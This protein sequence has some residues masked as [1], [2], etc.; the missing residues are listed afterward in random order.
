MSRKESRRA[1]WRLSALLAAALLVAACGETTEESATDLVQRAEQHLVAKEYRAAIIEAKN[2]LLK[3]AEAANARLVLARAY[4]ALGDYGSAEN[5]FLRAQRAGAPPAAYVA[6]LGETLL[7][8]AAYPRVLNLIIDEPAA[9][10]RVRADVLAVRGLAYL[11]QGNGQK[12]RESFNEALDLIPT[13]VRA[14]VGQ[15]RLD[16]FSGIDVRPVAEKLVAEHGDNP[17][18]LRLQGD[19]A[20]QTADFPTAVEAYGR[21][22]ALRPENPFF[23]MPQAYAQIAVG[24]TDAAIENVEWVLERAA[25]HPG[26]LYLRALAAHQMEDYATAEAFSTQTLSVLPDHLPSQLIAGSAGYALGHL[27]QAARYLEGYLTHV[28]EHE[29]ARKLHAATLLRL[30]KGD[31]AFEALEP[32][33]DQ[34]VGDPQTL[35]LLGQAAVGRGDFGAGRAF[36]RDAVAAKPDHA[37]TRAQLGIIEI[38]LGNYEA[39]IEELEKA[40]DLDPSFDPALFV[41]FGSYMRAE[42]Y[43][44]AL[45]VAG[46]YAES[47]PD[48][49]TGQTLAGIVHAAREDVDAAREAFEEALRIQPGAP[50]ASINLAVLAVR[51][52][53]TE[54]AR[55]ILMS[56]HE[57]NPRNV[58]IMIRLAQIEGRST[59]WRDARLWLE[60]AVEADPN[61][62]PPRVML[63]RLHLAAG[64]PLNALAVTQDYLAIRPD[65]VDVL[66]IVGQA[67]MVA[68]QPS[69]AEAT[70]R[71]LVD[72]QPDSAENF[73]LLAGAYEAQRDWQRQHDAISRA[74]AIDPD[75]FD[76]L[77]TLTRNYGH[78]EDLDKFRETLETLRERAPDNPIVWELTGNLAVAEDRFD[79]AV[80]DYRKAM[81]QSPEPNRGVA[82]KLAMAQ[83]QS[84]DRKASVATTADWLTRFPDDHLSRLEM[85]NRFMSMDRMP[86]AEV[87]FARLVE[88]LPDSWVARNNLAWVQLQRGELATAREHA[89][90]AATLSQGNPSVLDTLGLVLLAQDRVDR[91]IVTL[92]KA[93]DGL[94]ES[95]DVKVHLAQ[96]LAAGGQSDEA[97]ALLAEA[98]AGESALSDRDAAERLLAELGG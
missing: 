90:R 63:A 62:A 70:F 46:R 52:D 45:D 38:G 31:A 96:A 92:R 57:A 87:E 2:A 17:D 6:D 65:D 21:L 72:V 81:D 15:A 20:F 42:D 18:A 50:D 37:A 94:P 77:V 89:E 73:L 13:H 67:Q 55:Q 36:L 48:K 34:P 85:A 29:Q 49:S 24:Q 53:D 86:E 76:A 47:H 83:W 54:K 25:N 66:R 95:G 1:T 33:V 71:R 26:A 23:R 5:E 64:D 68:D 79:D 98:L 51:A 28:P 39:G 19:L 44:K 56:A 60:R 35:A 22:A 40:A 10:G 58:Q 88:A 4:A 75:S 41:L 14:R 30:R 69:R 80:A 93:L 16:S 91:A 59:N 8:V 82:L 7:A 3:D 27:E 97:R 61:Q 74:L 78:R 12:A 43:D 84:G 9:P 32:F 11:G